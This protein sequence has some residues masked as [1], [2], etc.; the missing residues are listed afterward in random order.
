MELTSSSTD[1]LADH[2]FG[3]MIDVSIIDT[4]RW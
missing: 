2:A 4:Y 1:K 3:V